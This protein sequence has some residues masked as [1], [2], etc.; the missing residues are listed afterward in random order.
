[1][2]EPNWASIVG[3]N[4]AYTYYPTYDEVLHAL[5]Q[6]TN[7]PVFL[8]EEHYEFENVGGELGTPPVLRHQ[9]YWTL[10]SG[11]MGQLYG[12]SYVWQFKSGWQTHL[13]SIGVRQ[14]QFGTA[15]FASRAWYNLIP[16]TNHSVLVSGYGDYAAAGWRARMIMR[17][18]PAQGTGRWFWRMC[19][20]RGR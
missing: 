14:L 13:D 16:D 2:D 3:L 10:L 19:R 15:L 7:T 8:G 20:Q 11:G 1:M 17:R 9:E 6:S 18:R 4:F 5:R 12:N